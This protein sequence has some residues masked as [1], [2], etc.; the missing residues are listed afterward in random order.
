MLR[1]YTQLQWKL[2]TVRGGLAPSVLQRSKMQIEA[3]LDQPLTLQTLAAEAGLSE[4]HFARMFRQSVG[5]APH[6]YV[7]K[8]RLAR[9]EALVRHGTQPI[10][11]IALACGFS[12]ASHL[13]HQFK[14]EYGMTPSA[15]RLAQK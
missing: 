1:G 13:S 6:Q 8:H 14:K 4:F 11:D 3:H 7:L 10:T 2:P 9:A 5:M 12:S 15:L